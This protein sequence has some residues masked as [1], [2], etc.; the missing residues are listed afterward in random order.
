MRN[1][2]Q[3]IKSEHRASPA[4]DLTGMLFEPVDGHF[5]LLADLD[6]V[7]VWIAHAATPLPAVRIGQ[8]LSEKDSAF[9]S[10]LFV[11]GPDVGDT[12]VQ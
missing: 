1:V 8:R 6:E 5:S 12:Q 11:A 2:V 9:I 10:P 7:A 3:R 4:V